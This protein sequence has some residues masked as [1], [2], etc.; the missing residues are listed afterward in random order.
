MVRNGMWIYIIKIYQ[1][2]RRVSD[3]MQDYHVMNKSVTRE[4]RAQIEPLKTS[5][6]WQLGNR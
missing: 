6:N 1:K 3:I 2:A 5:T 4:N